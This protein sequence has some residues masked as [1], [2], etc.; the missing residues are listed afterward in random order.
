[1]IGDY[2]SAKKVF[3][4]CLKLDPSS[5]IKG[6]LL[7]NLAM[8]Y[9]WQKFRVYDETER[10]KLFEQTEDSV[11]EKEVDTIIPLLKSAIKALESIYQTQQTMK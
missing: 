7:N 5:E 2:A 8:A 3:R 1:L 4:E 9:H 11:V 6:P 10:L